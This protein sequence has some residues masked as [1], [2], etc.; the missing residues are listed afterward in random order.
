MVLTL[1]LVVSRVAGN[2]DDLPASSRVPSLSTNEVAGVPPGHGVLRSLAHDVLSR[3]TTIGPP[4][5]EVSVVGSLR[6]G[7]GLAL[8]KESGRV[9]IVTIEEE[10]KGGS[11]HT[12]GGHCGEEKRLEGDHCE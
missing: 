9:D 12:G 5:V 7:S 3:A 2:T 11:K 4:G 1:T 8:L 10:V 6:A